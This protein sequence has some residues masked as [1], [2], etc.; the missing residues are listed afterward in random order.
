MELK[1]LGESEKKVRKVLDLDGPFVAVVCGSSQPS[2]LCQMK[3]RCAVENFVRSL[4]KEGKEILYLAVHKN[5]FDSLQRVG[6][7]VGCNSHYLVVDREKFLKRKKFPFAIVPKLGKK[8]FD[9]LIFDNSE[10]ANFVS[11]TADTRKALDKLQV[12]PDEIKQCFEKKG[13]RRQTERTGDDD[14]D[15]KCGEQILCCSGMFPSVHCSRV[16]VETVVFCDDEFD[17]NS[18]HF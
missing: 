6:S 3:K 15:D 12:L 18:I 17:N 14:N 9:G 5:L 1:R 4:E 7:Y 10:P 2:Q 16:F 8:K 11:T 13:R